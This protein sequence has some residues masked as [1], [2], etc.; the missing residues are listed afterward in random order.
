[1]VKDPHSAERERGF[2]QGRPPIMD[3]ETVDRTL[4]PPHKQQ[5]TRVE[6]SHTVYLSF[7]ASGVWKCVCCG[8]EGRRNKVIKHLF[9]A[10]Q[11]QIE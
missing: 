9:T 3:R 11:I 1:V 8:F 7:A 4:N 10:H 5:L 6:G 2:L